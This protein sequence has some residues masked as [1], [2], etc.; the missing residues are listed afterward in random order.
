M[1]CIWSKLHFECGLY[2]ELVACG[3]AFRVLGSH[4]EPHF[5]INCPI[6]RET[7]CSTACCVAEV[8]CA[9]GYMCTMHFCLWWY[10]FRVS[11]PGYNPVVSWGIRNSRLNRH[12]KGLALMPTLSSATV[13]KVDTHS[14]S[15]QEN[16]SIDSARIM[17][18]LVLTSLFGHMIGAQIWE[19][20]SRLCFPNIL[21]LKLN[22]LEIVLMAVEPD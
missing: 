11:L 22:D 7:R 12:S 9:V 19:Q 4:S 15:L 10:Q 3:T 5:L 1:V 16:T 6:T 14:S 8:G 17:D 13:T 2:C 20:L 21:A 18:N